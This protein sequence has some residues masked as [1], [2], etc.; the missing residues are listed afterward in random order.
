M[1][2]NDEPKARVQTPIIRV[3]SKAGFLSHPHD[4]GVNCSFEPIFVNALFLSKS[5]EELRQVY[6]IKGSI[7]IVDIGK[8]QKG[9]CLPK[10]HN[11]AGH[12]A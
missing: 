6:H 9:R 1:K 12:N 2:K 10:G 11:A 4:S 7:V 8:L 3:K 5:L